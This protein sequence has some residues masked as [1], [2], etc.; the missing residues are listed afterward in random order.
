MV[1]GFLLAGETGTIEKGKIIEEVVC[2]GNSSQ[3]Y[4]LYLPTAYNDK[5][6]W[7]VLF[8]F[9]PAARAVLPLKLFKSAAETYNYI[10]VCP[11]KVKNGP[12]TPI[13]NGMIAVWNDVGSR[14]SIDK[15]RIYATGFSGG[16]RMSSFFHLVIRNPVRGII[17]VGAGL[18]TA[19]KPEQVKSTLFYGIVGYTDFN[20][21]E[22]VRLEK[23]L[24]EQ[25][26]PHRFI[27]Y[28]AK[29]RWPPE[30][31]CT[32]ALEWIELISLK[33]K[34]IPKGPRLAFIDSSLEKERKLA[35]QRE[36][37]GEIF[38]AASDYEAIARTFEG[39]KPVDDVEQAAARLKE[40]KAFKKFQEDELKRLNDEHQYIRKFAWGLNVIKNS[41]PKTIRLP[42]ILAAMDI[43]VLDRI[44]KKKKNPYDAAM[45]ERV[46]YNLSDK[47]RQ[48]GSTSLRKKDFNRAVL[49]F[50]I[51]AAAGK[52]SFF[53]TYNLYNLACAYSLN[54][55]K[56]KALK[57]LKEAVKEGFNN[58]SLMKTDKDLDP[59][60]NNPG[61]QQI[62]RQMQKK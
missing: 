4:A 62:L 17:G 60:R 56:K 53:Y 15:Q 7:P 52:Y 27:Y 32:R 29:H 35:Q 40:S 36:Q 44:V 13:V 47:M 28:D 2:R 50:E 19:V 25:G 54:G 9:E 20:Y 5:E 51:A 22:M 23:T 48:E 1:S 34:R 57:T 46:L 24:K 12:R 33:E 11:T 31:I 18:S 61:F 45:A 42:R 38:Y 49:F 3:S 21:P 8:A 59:L 39:L 41:D 10:L 26:T 37:A 16:S 55:K 58:L 14:F 30:E 6:K 43:E